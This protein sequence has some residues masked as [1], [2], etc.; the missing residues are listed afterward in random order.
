VDLED[1]ALIASV[2]DD[3]SG[4]NVDA[5]EHGEATKALGIASMRQR[6]EMLGGQVLVE[7]LVGRGT[8]VTAM[9]P[10]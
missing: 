1:N 3:G 4:F 10:L 2:E 9:V 5:L 8:K 7:S 6:A